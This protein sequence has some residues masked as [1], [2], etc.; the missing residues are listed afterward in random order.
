M[1]VVFFLDF[2]VLYF[3]NKSLAYSGTLGV[4][5]VLTLIANR[6]RVKNAWS[7][8]TVGGKQMLIG[9]TRSTVPWKRK[10]GSVDY[11]N[12]EGSTT[13]NKNLELSG[14]KMIH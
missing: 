8:N 10:F 13:P 14:R 12:L 6:S 4:A 1:F 2:I 3:L 5:D 9:L 11:F 7:E